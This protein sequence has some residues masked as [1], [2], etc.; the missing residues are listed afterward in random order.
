VR[1]ASLALSIVALVTAVLVYLHCNSGLGTWVLYRSRDHLR[2][3]DAEVQ[4]F[5]TRGGADRFRARMLAHFETERDPHHSPFTL[6]VAKRK[7]R[8]A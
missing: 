3:P 8:A 1:A 7:G 6:Y 5:L 4:R 2:L